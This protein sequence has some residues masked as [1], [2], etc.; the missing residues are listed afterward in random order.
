MPR[1]LVRSC[2]VM[3]CIFSF[4]KA[5]RM[6]SGAALSGHLQHLVGCLFISLFQMVDLEQGDL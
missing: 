6:C 1:W 4:L 3:D 2:Q 5:Q